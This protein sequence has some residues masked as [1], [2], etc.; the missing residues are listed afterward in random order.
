[1]SLMAANV[2]VFILQVQNPEIT[3]K[4]SMV[5]HEIITG[6]DITQPV[7]LADGT[8]GLGRLGNPQGIIIPHAPTPISVYITLL[9]SMFLHGSLVHLLG[10]LLFL[11]IF[12]D[13]LEDALGRI[14]YL[15]FYILSGLIADVAHILVSQDPP[16]RYIPTLGASGAISG[17]L[18]G[19][20][21]LFPRSQVTGILLRVLVT[22]PA[23]YALGIWFIFQLIMAIFDQGGGVAYMAH[24]GGFVGGLLLAI[25]MGVRPDFAGTYSSFYSVTPGRHSWS[26]RLPSRFP[27]RYSQSG[28]GR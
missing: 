4:F 16:A 13:N 14:R 28:F 10:N 12:G 27:N 9:T 8:P 20:I 11:W 19:Y 7:D 21:Y 2:F 3:Y 25:L 24:I 5:P 18:G 22:I 6:E 15:V 1:W 26:G 17:V 23:A